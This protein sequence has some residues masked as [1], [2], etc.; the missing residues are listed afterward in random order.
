MEGIISGLRPVQD[1]RA[2]FEDVM[3]GR[4]LKQVVTF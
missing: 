4:G 3:K 2:A 1:T